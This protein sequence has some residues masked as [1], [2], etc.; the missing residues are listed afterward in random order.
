MLQLPTFV[1]N[2]TQLVVC[3]KL[4]L[5]IHFSQ[6]RAKSLLEKYF[7]SLVFWGGGL[8]KN[9]QTLLVGLKARLVLTAAGG[10]SLKN[11]PL[12]GSRT[13]L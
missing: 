8:G 3:G 2:L 10:R 11:W 13:L 5:K 12:S 4:F 6:G 1:L 7:F 9:Y